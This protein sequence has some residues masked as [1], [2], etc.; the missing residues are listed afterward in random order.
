M[1]TSLVILFLEFTNYSPMRNNIDTVRESIFSK[2]A[3]LWSVMHHP[4]TTST[5][6]DISSL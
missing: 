4:E 2:G 1:L 3:Q 6:L 5:L